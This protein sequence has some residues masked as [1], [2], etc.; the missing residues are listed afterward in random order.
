MALLGVQGFS[1][2]PTKCLLLCYG[3]FAAAILINLIKDMMGKKW[4]SL[5][6]LPMA[7]AIPFYIGPYFAIFD[8]IRVGKAKQGKGRRI[9]AGSRL[10]SH[11]RG[12][13]MDLAEFNTCTCRG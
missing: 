13:Y 7:M 8:L 2:L 6:P 11:L 10:R 5:V 4:G 9:R 12:G 1:A 3:F